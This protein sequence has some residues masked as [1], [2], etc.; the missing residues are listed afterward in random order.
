MHVTTSL[1][2]SLSTI[3]VC[4]LTVIILCQLF[5]FTSGAAASGY[6]ARTTIVQTAVAQLG[7]PYVW[8]GASPSVGFDCSGLV[9]YSYGKAGISLPHGASDQF[10]LC[11]P[12]AQADLYPGDL[13]F[14]GAPNASHVAMFV[15]GDDPTQNCVEALNA[16]VGL[17]FTSIVSLASWG[18]PLAFGRARASLWPGNDNSYVEPLAWAEPLASG[19]FNGDGKW[20]AGLTFDTKPGKKVSTLMSSGTA[21]TINDWWSGDSDNW[22]T[23]RTVAGDFNGDGKSDYAFVSKR[24]SGKLASVLLSN[25]SSFAKQTWWDN[26]VDNWDSTKV[27]AGDFN[28]DKKADIALV[29]DSNPGV[30]ITVLK[31]SGS[32]FTAET[33]LT[34]TTTAWNKIRVAAG[35]YSGDGKCDLALVTKLASGKKVTVLKSQGTSFGAGTDWWTNSVDNWDLTKVTS[36]DYTGDGKADIALVI[37]SSGKKITVL[38]STGTK[39]GNAEWWANGVDNWDLVKVTSGDYDGDKKADVGLLYKSSGKRFSVLKSTGKAFGAGSD[40]WT[41]NVDNWDLIK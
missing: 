7:L 21:M 26:G 16:K 6:T 15:G 9:L 13:I 18:S 25:G 12:V 5:V 22:A 4:I 1:R 38:T 34:N 11:D 17:H 10:A 33:W 41:N 36:G 30:K 40:W 23:T 2:R 28:G 8:G 19:D 31:S 29:V 35:D 14:V 3:S 37:K 24:N 32:G 27:A 39:F 20:D